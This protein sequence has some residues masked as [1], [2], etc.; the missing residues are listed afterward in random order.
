MGFFFPTDKKEAADQSA[1][2]FNN[3]GVLSFM[4][5]SMNRLK[6]TC[7]ETTGAKKKQKKKRHPAKFCFPHQMPMV[8]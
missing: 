8:L 1:D 5:P 2:K 4:P 3:K 6:I 7:A